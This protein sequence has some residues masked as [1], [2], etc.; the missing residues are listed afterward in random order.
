MKNRVK[1]SDL[2]FERLHDGCLLVSAIVENC[3]RRFRF[4]GYTKREA[5][6]IFRDKMNDEDLDW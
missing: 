4:Y 1:A 2:S 5:S 6:K 3:F